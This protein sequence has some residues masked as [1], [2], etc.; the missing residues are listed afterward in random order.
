MGEKIKNLLKIQL[1]TLLLCSGLAAHGQFHHGLELGAN[2]TQADFSIGE[3]TEDGP[4][5]GYLIGY[6]NKIMVLTQ[7]A[8][9]YVTRKRGARLVTGSDPFPMASHKHKPVQ[10]ATKVT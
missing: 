9:N 5:F 3:S 2:M 10:V 1:F 7:R 6:D 8:W 4:S